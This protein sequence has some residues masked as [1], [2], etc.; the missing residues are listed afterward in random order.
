MVAARSRTIRGPLPRANMLLLISANT[1]GR[2]ERSVRLIS[3]VRVCRKRSSDRTFPSLLPEVAVEGRVWL[4]NSS[5]ADKP[6]LPTAI[7]ITPTF[8]PY[9]SVCLLAPVVMQR[10]LLRG[11]EEGTLWRR[12]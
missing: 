6:D 8:C 5:T 12:G 4:F 11:P 10:E 7:R 1:K 2:P 3:L 9:E